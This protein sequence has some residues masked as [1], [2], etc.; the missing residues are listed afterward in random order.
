MVDTNCPTNPRVQWTLS[1][2]DTIG[3]EPNC[4]PNRGVRLTRSLVT[5][6]WLTRGVRL[7]EVSVLWRCPLRESWLYYVPGYTYYTRLH[8]DAFVLSEEIIYFKMSRIS[9]E[10]NSVCWQ[11]SFFFFFFSL[12]KG[13][14][15]HWD[16]ESKTK[17]M[18]SRNGTRIWEVGGGNSSLTTL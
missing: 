9:S 1:K 5:V 18:K 7:T 15:G 14:L 6:K 11:Y 10:G 16:W 4:P 8:R 2:T 13:D 17:K 3:T 12:G